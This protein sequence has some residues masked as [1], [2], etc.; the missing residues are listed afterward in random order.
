MGVL[1]AGRAIKRSRWRPALRRAHSG[2]PSGARA[3]AHSL[4]QREA[5]FG[6]ELEGAQV[7]NKILACPPHR[8]KTEGGVA[9]LYVMRLACAVTDSHCVNTTLPIVEVQV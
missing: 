4:G 1:A 6:P 2:D 9:W 7:R 5:V 8:H 3:R